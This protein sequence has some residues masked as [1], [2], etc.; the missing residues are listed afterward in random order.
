M[1]VTA[2][3][4]LSSR[5]ADYYDIPSCLRHLIDAELL[6]SEETAAHEKPDRLQQPAA[7]FPDV[8]RQQPLIEARPARR[9]RRQRRL[10]WGCWL[11]RLALGL[12]PLLASSTGLVSVPSSDCIRRRLGCTGN[13]AGRSID[14]EGSTNTALLVRA[15]PRQSEHWLSHGLRL[16]LE[17]FPCMASI[18]GVIGVGGRARGRS[19]QWH[20]GCGRHGHSRRHSRRRLCRLREVC[21]HRGGGAEESLPRRLTLALAPFHV[22]GG[23]RLWCRRCR[24]GL[25]RT[26]AATGG[27]PS[28]RPTLAPRLQSAQDALALVCCVKMAKRTLL[29]QHAGQASVTLL[30]LPFWS[31]SQ[32]RL[33]ERVGLDVGARASRFNSPRSF[34][35]LSACSCKYV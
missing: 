7:V 12:V 11:G 16:G 30:R 26:T 13:G 18:S 19:S 2:D 33:H 5:Q 32:Q 14:E 3:V 21:R 25:L 8:F 31:R 6:L 1:I 20:N 10:R 23:G 24:L 22:I 15:V 4:M 17:P 27:C 28:L 35:S 34:R 9:S 29:L